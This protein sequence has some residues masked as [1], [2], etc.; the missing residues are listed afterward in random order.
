MDLM[1]VFRLSRHNYIQ[2]NREVRM[3]IDDLLPDPGECEEMSR[4]AYKLQQA[5]EQ[6]DSQ[7]FRAIV[8]NRC[9]EEAR[10]EREKKWEYKRTHGG[11]AYL[12]QDY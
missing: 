8:E 7:R 1:D 5:Q 11:C 3:S 4:H 10:Y 9:A 2:R 12:E 6:G